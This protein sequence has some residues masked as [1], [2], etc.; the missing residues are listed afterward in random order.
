MDAYDDNA[1]RF[2]ERMSF[3]SLP[4]TPRKLFLPLADIALAFQESGA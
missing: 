4:D 1:R 2:Y 3:L